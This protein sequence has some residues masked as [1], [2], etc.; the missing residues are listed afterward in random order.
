MLIKTKLRFA[1]LLPAVFALLIGSLLW[2]S[3]I[4]ID[5][6]R[7]DADIAE[8]VLLSNFE[9]NVLTQE[10]L[11][12]GGKRAESQL[13]IRHQSMGELLAQLKY[14]DIKE[15]ELIDALRYGHQ[16][17]GSLYTLLLGGKI[18]AHG[19]LAGAL[20]IR[21]QAMRAKTQQFADIQHKRVLE[22]QRL[23]DKSI[24]VAM[25]L[26][27]GVS[28]ALLS[29]MARRLMQGIAQLN[30]GV[31][32]IAEGNLD[33]QI[34]LSTNDELDA[35]AQAFNDMSRKLR[36]SYTSIDNLNKEIIERKQAEDA[37]KKSQAL[38]NDTQRVSKLGGWEYDVASGRVYWSEEVY[39]LHG[40]EKESYDPSHPQRDIQFYAP[41]DQVHIA[42]AFQQAVDLGEPYDLE[43]QLIPARGQPL[44]V[45]TTG[46]VEKRN[47]KIVRVFGNIM[48]ITEAKL[49]REEILQLNTE[50]EQRVI[51]RTASLVAAN[52]ELEG[53][54]ADLEGFSY[55]VSHDLRAPLRAIDGFASILR[56]DYAPKLDEEGQRLFQVVSDNAQ[57]M[58][59]LIDDIL[60]FSHAGRFE[61]H[62]TMLDMNALVQQVWQELEPQRAGRLI[63]FRV[64]PL[65]SAS[66][67]PAAVRQVLQNLLANA[68]K[69]TRGRESA[70]I[71][72]GGRREANE[73]VYFIRDNGVGFDMAYVGKLFGMFQRLHGM[74]E[75]EG[76]GVGLA[77]V[78]RFV[79]K[80]CGRVWAIGKK[81]EGATFC[82]TLPAETVA[83]FGTIRLR[84]TESTITAPQSTIINLQS[85]K[86][87]DHVHK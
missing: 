60:A 37:L 55:S 38:L 32:R 33:Q 71:E 2:A 24:M 5:H 67:D 75:F 3:W 87:S 50:L 10:Y 29:L 83:K 63:E 84:N 54:N 78:K 72:V 56:E 12:Y 18:Q 25:I 9:L 85:N 81:G 68:V 82:F 27:A 66:G 53:A 58:G 47:G 13:R 57:K 6:A 42:K 69:F 23:T 65:P 51:E 43:L 15:Q 22:F 31:R 77:I 21:A 61:L 17:L 76:T 8:K 62:L 35:L 79:T 36:D 44:W 64:S 1:A 16:E 20:L 86:E 7:L 46:Q 39:R 41:D 49:A 19:Q 30:S 74:D 45:R 4:R 73:T 48:D 52:K 28:A 26:L 34:S 11:L 80:H 59:R 14:D 70:L 40:L